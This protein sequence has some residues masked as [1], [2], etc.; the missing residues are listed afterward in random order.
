MQA[1]LPMYDRPE[2]QAANDRLWAGIRDR[3][4]AAGLAAPETL[5]RGR[6]PLWDHWTA[7]DLVLSQTCGLPYRSRLH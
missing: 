1:S 6:W 3:L 2:V 5:V 4:R 7:P